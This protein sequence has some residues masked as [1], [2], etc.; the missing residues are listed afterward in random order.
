MDQSLDTLDQLAISL[1]ALRQ[2]PMTRRRF[3]KEFWDSIF[4]LAKTHSLNDICHRLHLDPAYVKAKTSHSQQEQLSF[5]ELS[6]PPDSSASVFIELACG[7][8]NAKIRGPV[9][10]IDH[11]SALFRR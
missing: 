10:C 1:D 6:L 5:C 7:S 11:I 4:Q 8:L 3:P 2:N 9:S